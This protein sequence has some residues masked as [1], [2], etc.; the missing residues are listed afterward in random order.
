ML[1]YEFC[2]L[3]NP[4]DGTLAEHGL[5]GWHVVGFTTYRMEKMSDSSNFLRQG[6]MEAPTI[7][8]VPIFYMEREIKEQ[9]IKTAWNPSP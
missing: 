2:K 7:V 9:E 1:Q 3:D 8:T 5:Q 4:S 6:H